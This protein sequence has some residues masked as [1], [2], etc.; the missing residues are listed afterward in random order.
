MISKPTDYSNIILNLCLARN[1]RSPSKSI[2]IN[3]FYLRMPGLNKYS[4]IDKTIVLIL[5]S[6]F[7]MS[8]APA[9]NTLNDYLQSAIK[10]SPVLAENRNQQSSLALDSMLF[11]AGLRPLVNFSAGGQYAP[12]FNGY[13]YDEIIT[14]GGNYNALLG[15]NYTIPGKK[16]LASKFGEFNLQQQMLELNSKMSERDIGR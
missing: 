16:Y 12:V 9:Q 14:N 1:S 3:I 6:C 11:R 2:F 10:N 7:Q 13:G 5:L 8:F 4:I 15:V